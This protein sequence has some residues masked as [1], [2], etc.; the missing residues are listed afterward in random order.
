MTTIVYKE[1]MITSKSPTSGT[2]RNVKTKTF[3]VQIMG[4]EP[5][6]GSGGRASGTGAAKSSTQRHSRGGSPKPNKK[7]DVRGGKSAK[8][9]FTSSHYNPHMFTITAYL[10][11]EGGKRLKVVYT[12]TCITFIVCGTLFIAGSLDMTVCRS[13]HASYMAGLFF[14]VATVFVLH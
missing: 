12:V 8:H 13:P 4:G 7:Y 1:E 5:Q 10:P 14:R 11:H 3:T 9:S 2:P 6:S